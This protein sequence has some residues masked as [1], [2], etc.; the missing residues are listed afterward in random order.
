MSDRSA[1]PRDPAGLVTG[2]ELAARSAP[3]W[4]DDPAP[5]QGSLFGA[6][7]AE[8]EGVGELALEAAPRGR[9]RP[10]G[11]RNRSTEEWSRFLLSRYRSPLLGLAEIAQASPLDLQRELGGAPAKDKPEGCSLV[12]ALR[13]IMQ[14]QQALAPYLHQ[15][16]PTA[17]D[18]GGVAMMQ[19]IINAGSGSETGE[20][21]EILP[22]TETV[23]YQSLSAEEREGLENEGWNE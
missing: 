23:E 14:A 13:L 12:E 20:T 15:K 8:P 19:V 18:G 22:V 5:V 2:A 16:Q 7:V 17:I 9:G 3:G 4:A 10:P 21:F 11:S 1:P 6:E